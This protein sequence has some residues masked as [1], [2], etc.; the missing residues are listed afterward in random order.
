MPTETINVTPYD[1]TL[2]S[3]DLLQENTTLVLSAFGSEQS[4]T[5]ADNDGTLSTDDDGIS[6]LNGEPVTYIGGG[7]AQVGLEEPLTGLFV[8]LGEQVE[9][10]VLEA[11]GDIFFHYPDGAPG[12][13]SAVLLS[14]NIDQD[15][16]VSVFA[17]PYLGT[18]AADDFTGDSFDNI[19]SGAGDDDT[20]AGA[21]GDDEIAGGAGNDELSGG[22]GSDTIDG[23]TGADLL[24]GGAGSDVIEGGDGDDTV[25]AG[26]AFQDASASGDTSQI[27]LNSETGSDTVSGVE[28]FEFTDG[29]VTAEDLLAGN[30]PDDGSGGGDDGSDGGDDGSGG[31]DDGSDG[32]D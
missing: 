18:P 29:V 12:E 14:L 22:T 23:G 4:A 8:S 16:D 13:L 7:T 15:Q 1:G 10:A 27:I 2:V 11:G 26:V 24:N 6:T 19:M 5:F 9:V 28:F 3:A 30:G 25:Q 32:G 21:G 31:G 20:I 17:N